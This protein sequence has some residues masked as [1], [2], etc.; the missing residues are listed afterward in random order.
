[1]YIYIINLYTSPNM[2]TI[3]KCKKKTNKKRRK[4]QLNQFFEG[5]KRSS[6]TP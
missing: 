4:K 5:G 2:V 1:M 6:K 3:K